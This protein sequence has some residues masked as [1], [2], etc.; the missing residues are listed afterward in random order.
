MS[1]SQTKSITA[2]LLATLPEV[3]W[4]E[5]NRRL[6]LVPELWAL[7][8]DEDVLTALCALGDDPLNWRPGPL[9]LAAYAAKHP[10]CAGNAEAWLLGEGRERVT[11]AYDRL[12]SSD[13]LLDPLDEALPAALALRRRA[14]TIGDWAALAGEATQSQSERWRLPLQYL[15]GLLEFPDDLLTALLKGSPTGAALAGQCLVVNLA[16]DEAAKLVAA[17]NLSLPANQWLKFVQVIQAMGEGNLA[18]EVSPH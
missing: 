17:L 9:A 5:A 7:A 2:R 13:S 11:A 10:E 3:I 12:I 6:R 8:E 1:L 16:S 14:Y 18:R 4:A 15:W